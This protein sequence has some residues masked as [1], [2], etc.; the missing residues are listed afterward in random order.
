MRKKIYYNGINRGR[1]RVLG[2]GTEE[3]ILG[4]QYNERG[5]RDNLIVTVILIVIRAVW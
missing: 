5:G 1:K 3:E 2:S 4:I